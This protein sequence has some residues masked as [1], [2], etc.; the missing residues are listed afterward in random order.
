MLNTNA[1]SIAAPNSSES[2][3]QL[4]LKKQED[5]ATKP[6]SSN[7]DGGKA[8]IKDTEEE[9]RK[10]LTLHLQSF[11][12]GNKPLDSTYKHLLLQSAAASNS[13]SALGEAF[14]SSTDKLYKKVGAELRL[15]VES[16]LDNP[17]PSSQ[18]G[19]ERQELDPVQ[20]RAAFTLREFKEHEQRH[21]MKTFVSSGGFA[22]LAIPAGKNKSQILMRQK[23]LEATTLMLQQKE[24]EEHSRRATKLLKTQQGSSSTRP[25][26]LQKLQKGHD[27]QHDG[28]T[29]TEKEDKV[30]SAER[31][32]Q[33][34]RDRE[35]SRELVRKQEEEER[36]NRLRM[37]K[38]EAERKA[39]L[40]E[41]PRQAL[42]RLYEPVFQA[43]WDMEFSN[44]HGTNPF[45]I[46]IDQDNCALMGVPDYCTI[47]SKP[48]NLTW[49]QTKMSEYKYETLQEF[50][51]DVELMIKNSLL[52]NSDPENP[53][54]VAAKE[55]K[56]Q[57]K[58]MAK[59]LIASLQQ[60][61]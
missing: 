43:L 58:K 26:Q 61:T 44:L 46:I 60:P 8:I 2:S 24:E 22:G 52:Y 23:N 3:H 30:V 12:S 28:S 48:M 36:K 47:V 57:F 31:E 35:R 1:N 5:E 21:F 13:K 51:A 39:R 45:R 49:I 34:A 16:F 7:D 17:N 41:T 37:E 32:K 4:A 25:Q 9:L 14:K 20:M 42:R 53:Y 11:C 15:A 6:I 29:K 10:T 50:F 38:E 56:K 33:L 55:M 54:H 40:A 19:K 27:Q 59:S 18:I